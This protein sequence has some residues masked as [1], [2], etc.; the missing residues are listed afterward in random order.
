MDLLEHLVVV[1][2]QPLIQVVPLEQQQVEAQKHH[3]P[4][5]RIELVVSLMVVAWKDYHP[6]QILEALDLEDLPLVHHTVVM[7]VLDLEA[8]DLVLHSFRVH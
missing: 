8:L 7:E 2:Y 1:A 5:S 4:L 3:H 6:S